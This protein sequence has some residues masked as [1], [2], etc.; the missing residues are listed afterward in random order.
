MSAVSP[1]PDASSKAP[2][3]THGHHYDAVATAPGPHLATDARFAGV[4]LGSTAF[5][6]ND[7][8]LEALTRYDCPFTALDLRPLL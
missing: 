1:T 3:T 7:A 8:I 5:Q 2:K 4:A 6:I